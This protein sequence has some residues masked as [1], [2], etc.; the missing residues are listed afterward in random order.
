MADGVVYVAGTLP[1]DA[2]TQCRS[3]G[4]A[5]AQTQHV[6]SH[7]VRDRDRRGPMADVTFNSIFITDWANYATMNSVY[8]EVSSRR[9]T[10]ALL[11]PVR[12]GEARCLVEIASIAHKRP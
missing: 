8:A 3:V 4:D 7:Q 11:H 6:L 2:E 12:A 1:L 5:A 9:Q 10:G